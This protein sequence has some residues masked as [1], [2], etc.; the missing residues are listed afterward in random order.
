MEVN[1]KKI[2]VVG[3]ARTGV[4]VA[5]FMAERG[6]DVVVTDMKSA[7]AL[8]ALRKALAPNGELLVG[9]VGRLAVEKRI[10]LLATVSRRPGIKVV[11]VGDGPARAALEK[12]MPG[13]VF[14][15]ERHGTQLAKL[16]ASLDVFVHT[17]PL[18]TFCQAPVPV[19]TRRVRS[20]RCM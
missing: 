19:R 4:A 1:N 8:A 18:E 3:L 13:A 7:D 9:Y 17:G 16:Y 2:V 12:T 5:R 6:A 14:V 10:D 20:P 11:I 15:G